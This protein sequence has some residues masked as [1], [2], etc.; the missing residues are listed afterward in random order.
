[1]KNYIIL[2][3]KGIGVGIANIIPG[4]SGGTIALI[5][6]IFETLL[7]SIKS[8]DI[9]AIK[10]LF[11]GKFRKFAEYTN[12]YFLIAVFGGAVTSVFA[13]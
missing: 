11:K 13:L 3:L 12:L 6:G 10:L 4:V 5:V 2:F 1:M 7:N 9:T 8:F